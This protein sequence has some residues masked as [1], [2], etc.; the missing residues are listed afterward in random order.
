MNS[1]NHYAYGAIGAWLY[2][3]VAGIDFDPEAPGYKHVIMR[4]R[5]GGGLTNAKAELKS[6]YGTVHSAWVME[7][8]CFDWQISIPA[9]S[10]ATITIPAS[11]HA[12]IQENGVAA[13]NANNVSLLRR[14]NGAA[15]YE[16]GS[17]DYHFIAQ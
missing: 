16:I 17:G 3:V 15:V 8:G 1:F 10:I 9:N 13:E 14:E 4:P 7:N 6:Q 5:P 12:K 2:A 11:E